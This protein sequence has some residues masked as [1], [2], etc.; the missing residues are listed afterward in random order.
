MLKNTTL[1]RS[2]LPELLRELRVGTMLDAACGDCNWI[3]GVDLGVRY[4]GADIDKISLRNARRRL[5]G[6]EWSLVELDITKGALPQADLV[7]CRDCLQHL[8]NRHVSRFLGNFL[9]SR[10]TWLLATSHRN[11][12]NDDIPAAGGYRPLNLRKGPFFLPEPR[13]VIEDG[14][15]DLALW[16]RDDVSRQARANS[17][18]RVGHG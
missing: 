18:L 6:P 16:H 13:K 17:S 7:L 2:N 12:R 4:I 10:N 9:A 11:A 14:G 3:S 15:R 5:R 8:P 1:V